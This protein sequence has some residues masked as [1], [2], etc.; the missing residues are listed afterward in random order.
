MDILAGHAL[1]VANNDTDR[2][3]ERPRAPVQVTTPRVQETN[4]LEAEAGLQELDSYLSQPLDLPVFT[5]WASV[6]SC[7]ESNEPQREQGRPSLPAQ[8]S[9][10]CVDFPAE[11]RDVAPPVDSDSGMAFE[12]AGLFFSYPPADAEAGSGFE[13]TQSWA[14]FLQTI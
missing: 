3:Y 8:G 11:F 5:D 4:E 14:D 12:D 13:N 7:A 10:L 6:G 2:K 1:V 9:S